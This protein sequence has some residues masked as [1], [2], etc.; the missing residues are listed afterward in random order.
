MYIG[1]HFPS[2]NIYRLF[3][4]NRFPTNKQIPV[5]VRYLGTNTRVYIQNPY[6]PS[7]KGARVPLVTPVQGPAAEPGR[8]PGPMRSTA[9]SVEGKVRSSP[10]HRLPARSLQQPIMESCHCSGTS[11]GSKSPEA[12]NPDQSPG[13]GTYEPCRP[14]IS[15]SIGTLLE[16]YL[17]RYI[18][19]HGSS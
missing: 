9:A 4:S 11:A 18:M 5:H 16:D 3:C 1:T 6:C 15:L 13:F 19:W 10:H 17:L 12:A 14:P 7:W 2:L 8:K